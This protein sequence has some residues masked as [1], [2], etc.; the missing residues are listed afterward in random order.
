[1]YDSVCMY[2]AIA[3]ILATKYICTGK[4]KSKLLYFVYIFA[5]Y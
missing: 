3:T 1:V 4:A 2:V 5:K